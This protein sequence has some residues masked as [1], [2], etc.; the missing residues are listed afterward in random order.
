[1]T[2][3]QQAATVAAGIGLFFFALV[4]SALI[5]LL[6]FRGIRRLR[7]ALAR[8]KLVLELDLAN[9][10]SES[11][12]SEPWSRYLGGAPSSFREVLDA[13]EHGLNDSRVVGIVVRCSASSLGLAQSEEL[14]AMLARWGEQEKEVIALADTFGEGAPG[15]LPF[16]V[17]SAASRVVMQPSGDLNLA[18]LMSEQPFV[19]ELL[20]RLG[21][22]PRF[23]QRYE[24]KSVGEI[25]TRREM[26]K[27][28]KESVRK[29]LDG[30]LGTLCHTV[31]QGRGVSR[32]RVDTVVSEGPYSASTALEAGFVDALGYRHDVYEALRKKH[33][34]K[35]KFRYV[36]RYQQKLRARHRRGPTVALVVADGD[37]VRGA[38]RIDL[39]SRS[40]SVGSD[41]VGGA[42]RA[43]RLDDDVRG[44]L[45]RIN[46]RGGSYIGSDSIWREVK[47][48]EEDGKPVVAS[49]GDYAASGGYY[50]ATAARAIVSGRMTLTGSIGV[51]GGKFVLRDA[52]EKLGVRFDGVTTHASA[53]IYSAN[54][55]YDDA[56]Q[57]WIEASFDRAYRDFVTKVS[58]ARNMEADVLDRLARG[59]VWT[60]EQALEVGLVD[61]VGG[62]EVA[63]ERLKREAQISGGVTLRSFPSPRAP[64]AQLLGGDR[65]SSEDE[66][67]SAGIAR[68]VAMLGLVLFG[69][70]DLLRAFDD[71]RPG[72][73]R[74]EAPSFF[75]SSRGSRRP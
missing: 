29:I 68:R 10:L 44:V 69:R 17:A 70:A 30:V 65:D 72:G 37:I 34:S 59:R 51:A 14:R 18:G 46:S 61:E 11:A 50:I 19:R 40:L 9:A 56:G 28:A 66:G 6:A 53:K 12:S 22:L 32:E 5:G 47:A 35:L 23:Q 3:W 13:L 25:F 60:G 75:E 63:L 62:F 55:D 24:Y 1:M 26:S 33:G 7:R 71:L 39:R 57:R 38:S 15:W 36:E 52:W 27:P 64:W 48:L 74:L 73:V 31:A 58:E 54:H 41:T 45:L 49:F 21:V 16:Y 2:F 42:L 20:D 8:G 67:R 43:A 4:V